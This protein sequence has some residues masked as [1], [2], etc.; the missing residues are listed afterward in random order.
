MV[1]AR[2]KGYRMAQAMR[3]RPEIGIAH[4]FSAQALPGGNVIRRSVPRVEHEIGHERF[5]EETRLRGFDLPENGA[6]FAAICPR[7]SF[8]KLL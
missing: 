5:V 6:Q 7:V 8:R 4:V 2:N 3:H 1:T